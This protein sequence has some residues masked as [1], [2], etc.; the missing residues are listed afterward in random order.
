M[1]E[2]VYLFRNSGTPGSPQQMQEQMQ[3]WQAWMKDLAAR[4][5]LKSRGNALERTG[6]IVGKDGAMTD[7]PFTEAKDIVGGF[8]GRRGRRSAPRGEA[9]LRVSGVR[10]GGPRRSASRHEDVN[11]GSGRRRGQGAVLG[12]HD[13]LI[14][15]ASRSTRRPMRTVADSMTANPHTIG[16]AQCAITALQMMRGFGVRHLPVL[17]EGRLVG[18]LSDPSSHPIPEGQRRCRDD[19][20]DLHLNLNQN[21]RG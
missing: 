14:H 16:A 12:W 7:G 6:T 10:D 19:Q 3:R 8:H 9:R 11:D 21:L 17:D 5:H 2:F 1:S 4:G 20:H 15:P 18:F 13:I